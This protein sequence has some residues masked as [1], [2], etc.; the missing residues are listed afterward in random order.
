[1]IIDCW[2]IMRLHPVPSFQLN[3]TG[4]VPA[5]RNPLA[6]LSGLRPSRLVKLVQSQ[7]QRVQHLIWSLEDASVI[8][9]KF[10][11]KFAVK[12][13]RPVLMC[14]CQGLA[15]TD[16]HVLNVSCRV[17]VRMH[18]HILGML[19]WLLKHPWHAPLQLHVNRVLSWQW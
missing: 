15:A 6:L 9:G 2:P 19:S 14:E 13:I 17:V 1:M 5:G 16:T 4:C 8:T 10:A 18:H 3:S 12:A 7:G 11:L